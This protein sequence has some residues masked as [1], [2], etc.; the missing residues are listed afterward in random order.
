MRSERERGKWR[1]EVEKSSGLQG[2]ALLF[3]ESRSH[4]RIVTL[5]SPHGVSSGTNRVHSPP[6]GEGNGKRKR[7]IGKGGGK[8]N[9]FQSALSLVRTCL[10]ESGSDYKSDFSLSLR[11][12]T[13]LKQL[14]VRLSFPFICVISRCIAALRYGVTIMHVSIEL[15]LLFARLLS[16]FPKCFLSLRM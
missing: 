1:E 8:R 11:C 13:D 7:A 14:L 16:N 4:P 15:L 10:C 5:I 9:I 2:R 6:R 3:C 12:S